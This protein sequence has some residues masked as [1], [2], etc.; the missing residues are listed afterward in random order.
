ML[1]IR[2]E[3]PRRCQAENPLK[4]LSEFV[5]PALY[6]SV[7]QA[8]Q[9]RFGNAALIKFTYAVPEGAAPE[10]RPWAMGHAH[11]VGP[12]GWKRRGVTQLAADLSKQR[13]QTIKNLRQPA[14]A[15]F[16]K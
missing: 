15:V 9:A 4:L 11:G 2:S 5:R 7:A 16:L 14:I 6:Q 13:V 10:L 8:A 12:A 1:L 3:N